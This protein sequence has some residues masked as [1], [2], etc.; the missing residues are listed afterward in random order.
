MIQ[1][2]LKK[3]EFSAFQGLIIGLQSWSLRVVKKTGTGGF[4]GGGG[5]D[6]DGG[7]DSR[8]KASGLK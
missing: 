2:S 1:Y 4:L 6:G 5:G 7:L 8:A 3:K